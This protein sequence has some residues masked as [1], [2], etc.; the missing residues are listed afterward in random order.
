MLERMG[1][2]ELVQAI[3]LS[4]GAGAMPDALGAHLATKLSRGQLPDKVLDVIV[5]A[6]SAIVLPQQLLAAWSHFLGT[7]PT[8]AKHFLMFA[9]QT[10]LASAHEASDQPMNGVG[11]EVRVSMRRLSDGSPLH[12]S[13]SAPRKKDAENLASA[14]LMCLFVGAPGIASM[15]IEDI[16]QA[17]A[18]VAKPAESQPRR[19][20]KGELL[21]L[22]QK[23]RIS[24][25]SFEV[26]TSGPPN[27]ARF[28]CRASLSINAE[29]KTGVFENAKP[30][31]D[32]EAG[33]SEQLLGQILVEGKTP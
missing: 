18:V 24:P 31:K 2:P 7:E 33:A 14:R 17:A 30:K 12:A 26:G 10:G 6:T 20:F 3:K 27:D 13:A 23:K 9:L 21:E 11:F 4:A 1:D 28:S 16:P 32:A 15:P 8:R 22:C 29:L 25:P 5:T 19:N